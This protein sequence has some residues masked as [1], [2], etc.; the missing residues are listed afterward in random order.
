MQLSLSPAFSVAPKP[1]SCKRTVSLAAPRSRYGV[2][3][4]LSMVRAT[5]DASDPVPKA[6]SGAS[7][8]ADMFASKDL[9][10]DVLDTSELGSR[11]EGW[12]VAQLAAFAVLLFPP[13]GLTGAVDSLA[14]LCLV[15]GLTLASISLYNLGPSLS[16][17]P[18]PRKNHALVTDGLYALSRHPMYGGVLLAAL[19][20]S[21]LSHNETRLLTTIGLWWILDNKANLEEKALEE[22]YPEYPQYKAKVKKF[23]P[24]LL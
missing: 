12:F 24:Y 4:R 10:E 13:A 20:L 14:L 21:V 9:I 15:S 2:P 11:G 22:L 7:T 6:K 5:D 18:K 19:G 1:V 17:L 23:I 3:R 8:D 16:P